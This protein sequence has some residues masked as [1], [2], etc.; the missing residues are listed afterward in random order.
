MVTV[1]EDESWLN[2]ESNDAEISAERDGQITVM[3]R[4][5]SEARTK[6]ARVKWVFALKKAEN[7]KKKNAFFPIWRR[8]ALKFSPNRLK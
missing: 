1:A 6:R 8:V 5:T 2:A 3:K 7:G 4:Q